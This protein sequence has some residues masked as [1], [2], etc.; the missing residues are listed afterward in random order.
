LLRLEVTH[1]MGHCTETEYISVAVS[2]LVIT[3][4]GDHSNGI[5][6][7]NSR[8]LHWLPLISD[9]FLI[10]PG[11]MVQLIFLAFKYTNTTFTKK[12][13]T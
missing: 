3:T 9:I 11:I 4:N 5:S 1:D 13:S 2:A 6:L 8:R 12:N 7:I 10:S